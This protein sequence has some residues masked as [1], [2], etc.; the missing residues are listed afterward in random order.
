MDRAKCN[1]SGLLQQIKKTSVFLKISVHYQVHLELKLPFPA[2]Q[3][4]WNTVM[5]EE[6]IGG[7]GSWSSQAK[8][9][10][11]RVKNT[12]EVKNIQCRNLI[13][14]GCAAPLIGELAKKSFDN[15]H[16]FTEDE[17]GG[18]SRNLIARGL[19]YAQVHAYEAAGNVIMLQDLLKSDY[20]KMWYGQREYQDGLQF[21]N[22]YFEDFLGSQVLA[23]DVHNFYH[24]HYRH[25]G[26]FFRERLRDNLFFDSIWKNIQCT[27]AY[28]D[29]GKP[30]SYTAMADHLCDLEQS[31]DVTSQAAAYSDRQVAFW[32]NEAALDIYDTKAPVYIPF[33]PPC[34]D[35]P[36]QCP[37]PKVTAKVSKT[38]EIFW[39]FR[40]L[41]FEGYDDVSISAL[42]RGFYKINN[43]IPPEVCRVLRK[44][45]KEPEFIE[46]YRRFDG[47]DCY[48]VPTL[49]AK[50][51]QFAPEP[52]TLN[53]S[54]E[55][56]LPRL[57]AMLGAHLLMVFEDYDDGT[58]VK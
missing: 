35:D 6:D 58:E 3:A 7:Q 55:V 57:E 54:W 53:K 21:F 8:A 44:K 4:L 15:A 16:I 18:E 51:I 5:E 36:V 48:D 20:E 14:A 10:F 22:R 42:S 56:I 40:T 34:C 52:E 27:L 37:F 28:F 49:M 26:P 9:L 12:A 43:L 39:V 29:D 19:C 24:N 32:V 45:T 38:D 31:V 50:S 33:M 25:Y 23:L 41:C 30:H 17:N 47:N 13:L 11:N 46:R 2:G 1:V